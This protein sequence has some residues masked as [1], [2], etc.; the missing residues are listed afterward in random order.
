MGSTADTRRVRRALR[1]VFGGEVGKD[2]V[3]PVW[4]KV[5]GD[6]DRWNC[7]SLAE[8]PVV[9]LILDGT[10]VRVRLDRKATSISLLVVIGARE[11]GQK[12]LLAIKQ[13]GRR[14]HRGLAHGPR[15]SRQARPAAARVPHRRWRRGARGS[16][17]PALHLHPLAAKPV[18]Q[19]AHHQRDRTAIRGVQAQDQNA[20][21][22][23]VGGH[24]R[25][26]VLGVTCL[27]RPTCAK[28][29]V[30]E[31]SP[32]N[33]LI[34]HLISPQRSGRD[35]ISSR[36]TDNSLLPK[37]PLALLKSPHRPQE[38]DLPE[39]WPIDICKVELAKCTL[40]K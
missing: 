29:M 20:D 18:A 39:R 25:H 22:A 3:S 34:S 10:V 23:A 17:R 27:R 9:R 19:R 6:W 24:G 38:I 4:R 28:S 5:K 15:R 13:K 8:E 32:Q 37:T 40:P 11:D 26:V 35:Q 16:R 36:D 7:R 33:P 21:C 2:T 14:E 30:G 12:V 1:S 31:P